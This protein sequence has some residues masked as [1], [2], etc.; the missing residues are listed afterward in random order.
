MKKNVINAGALSIATL[1]LGS[2]FVASAFDHQPDNTV[3]SGHQGSDG[4]VWAT[5]ASTPYTNKAG[6]NI[7]NAL[8]G[9]GFHQSPIA[10]NLTS[11]TLT[12][13]PVTHAGDANKPATIVD[14]QNLVI[15][16]YPQS[17]SSNEGGA[18]ASD[19]SNAYVFFN[20][21][22]VVKVDLSEGYRG[23][24]LVGHDVYPLVQFHFH[25]PSE[26]YVVTDNYPSGKQYDGEL[27]FVHQNTDGTLVVLAVFLET[28]D[29]VKPNPALATILQNTPNTNSSH[30]TPGHAGIAAYN[31]SPATVGLLLH[32]LELIPRSSTKVFTYEG[33]LTTP[34]CSEGVLWFVL[35]EPL[36]VPLSQI[37]GLQNFYTGNNR[38]IQNTNNVSSDGEASTFQRTVEIRYNFHAHP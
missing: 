20:D 7:P 31:T 17:H 15:A 8:C 11:Q 29:A 13:N 36:K 16:R 26:H 3:N 5:I 6:L 9:I 2:P 28:D 32:P 14:H 1:L 12:T 25:A 33:G 34:Q 30:T 27:H 35:S 4:T 37:T 10:I 19:A 18:V 21:G 38:I 22:H 24:L 23:E